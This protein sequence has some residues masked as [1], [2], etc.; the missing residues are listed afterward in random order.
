MESGCGRVPV[1][2]ISGDR[3]T[4]IIALHPHTGGD[5]MHL[6][7]ASDGQVAFVTLHRGPDGCVCLNVE[8]VHKIPAANAYQWA[9]RYLGLITEEETPIV[10]ENR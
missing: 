9:A 8:K 7:L 10:K 1:V 6:R 5:W 4:E 3:W 2:F